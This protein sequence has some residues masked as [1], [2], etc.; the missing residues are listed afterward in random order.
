MEEEV[1]DGERFLSFDYTNNSKYT[2]LDVE[3]KYEQKEGITQEQY[4]LFDSL[5]EKN[6]YLIEDNQDIYIVGYNRK[7]AEPG[8]SVTTSPVVINGTSYI[9]E[10]QEEYALFEPDIMTIAFIG[11]DGKGYGIYYDYKSKKFSASSAGSQELHAWSDSELAKLL[12]E[13][14]FKADVVSTDEEDAFFVYVYGIS[15]QDYKSYIKVVQEKGFT[16]E[17]L[18]FNTSYS[19]DNDNGIKLSLYYDSIEEKMDIFLQKQ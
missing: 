7:I 4:A 17:K 12:P 8:K 10:N 3:L 11:P 15:S 16:K 1:N 9:V 19:A 5:K 6:P 18:E 13:P 2:I 14:D